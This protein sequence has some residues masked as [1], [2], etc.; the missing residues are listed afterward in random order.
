[1]KNVKGYLFLLT[2]RFPRHIILNFV[3]DV[4]EADQR[5]DPGEVERSHVPDQGETHPTHRTNRYECKIGVSH[6]KRLD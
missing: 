6:P 3:V 4:V 1:M 2:V 5:A